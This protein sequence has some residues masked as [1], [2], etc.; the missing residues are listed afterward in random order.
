MTFDEIARAVYRKDTDV[1]KQ[2]TRDEVNLTDE[3]GRTPLMHAV[4]AEDADPSIVRLLIDRGADVNA[5]DR[6]GWTALHFGGRD[7][8]PELVRILL[9][10]CAEVDPVDAYGDTPLWR[11]VSELG[12]DTRTVDLLLERG[13]DPER[14]NNYGISPLDLARE[15]GR[16][17][18]LSRAGPR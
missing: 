14:K 5:A 10:A 18:T 4:L 15:L 13:A 2:L 3:D 12:S 7:Q 8:N 11:A 17:D 9:D 1:L 16:E 6:Q